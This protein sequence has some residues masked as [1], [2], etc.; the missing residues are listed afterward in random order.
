VA[1]VG[2]VGLPGSSVTAAEAVLA[3]PLRRPPAVSAEPVE[4]AGRPCSLVPAGRAAQEGQ[5]A[6]TPAVLVASAVLAAT[7]DYWWAPVVSAV[8]VALVVAPGATAVLAAT[9]GVL[10]P[11]V[12]AATAGPL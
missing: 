6:R 12:M 8:R 3:D 7:E 10:V 5:E 9:G 1:T 4:L 11:E 2:T